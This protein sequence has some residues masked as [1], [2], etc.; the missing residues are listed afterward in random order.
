[1]SNNL[2]KSK[3]M[4]KLLETLYQASIGIFNM[5]HMI[6]LSLANINSHLRTKGEAMT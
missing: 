2:N 4:N 6:T 3:I 1:M 5:K